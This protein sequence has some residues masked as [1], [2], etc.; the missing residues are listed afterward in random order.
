MGNM[1]ISPG[2]RDVVLAARKGLFIID[3]EN[4]LNVPR[5]LP[6]GGTWDVADVQWN[7]HISRKEY[8]VSTS[9]EKLLIWNL[10]ISGKT[11]IEHILRSHYRAITD[12]NWHL[13]DPD[14]VVST[15]IDSWLWAW[16][17]RT[18]QKPIIGLCAFN[19][20]GT[21]VKWNRQDGNILASS[22]MNEVLVWDRRKGSLPVT[23][24]KAHDAKIY[25]IDWAHDK[26]NE[27]VTCSLDTTI[28]AWDILQSPKSGS[29]HE[30]LYTIHT[31][32]P[33]WRARNLPF[34]KGVLSLPQRGETA[35]EMW[36]PQD[37][38]EPVERFEGHADVVKEFV[39]RKGGQDDS[40][41]QLITWSKDRT[42]RFWPVDRE[43]MEKVG[44]S[45]INKSSS[46]P[47]YFDDRVSFSNPPAGSEPPPALSAPI[48]HRSILAEVRATQ[49]PR[50]SKVNVLRQSQDTIARRSSSAAA[51]K[52]AKTVQQPLKERS[53]T[54]SRGYVG[55]RSAQITTFAWLSSVKVGHK[56][57]TSSGP[58]SGADSG[59]A[60]RLNSRSRPPSVVDPAMSYLDYRAK[61]NSRDR[62]DEDRREVD[63]NQSLQE[64][65]T[66]V[67][68]RL[69][70]SKVKLEKADLV[71][72]RTCTFGLHGPWGDGMSVFIRIS[73][74]FPKDYPQASHPGGTPQ[75][76]LERN[77]LI[78]MK[79][80][81][82]ILRR[83][84]VIREQERPC[85]EACLRF[86]LF[87]DEDTSSRAPSLDSESSSE[88][89]LG[90]TARRPKEGTTSLLR[91]DKNLAEPR[92]SQGVFGPNGELVCFFRAPPRIVK[93]IGRDIS[94]SPSPGAHSETTPRLF[95]SPILLSDA[96]RRL[97]VAANDREVESVD[98]R[99]AENAHS[100]LRIMS[101]LFTFSSQPGQVGQKVR[102]V[103]EHSKPSE[104]AS[105]IYSPLPNRRSTVYIKDTS[106]LCAID[107]AVARDYVF[108]SSDLVAACKTNAGLAKF[109]GRLDH[110]RFFGILQVLAGDTQKSGMGHGDRNSSYAIRNPMTASMMDR[111]YEELSLAKDIQML[112]MFS[113]VVLCLAAETPMLVTPSPMPRTPHQDY[114]TLR[115]NSQ[116]RQSP[117]SN[118]W[119]RTSPSPSTG[120][121]VA[122][123]LSSPSS[124]RGSWSS[125]FNA[126]SMRKLITASKAGSAVPVSRSHYSPQSPLTKDPKRDSPGQQAT[127]RSWT[128]PTK[129]WSD[130]TD[131]SGSRH[132]TLSFSSSGP[133][134]RRPTFSQ[135]VSNS[136]QP[137]KKRVSVEIFRDMK[138]QRCPFRLDPRLRLQL[139]AHVWAYADM[140]LAWGLSQKRAE[141]LDATRADLIAA[142]DLTHSAMANMFNSSPLGI[143]RT[144]VSCSQINEPK[145]EACISCSGRLAVEA[146]SICRLPVR[147]LSHTCLVC[148]HASHVR[149]WRNRQDPSCPTGCG[150]DCP[151]SVAQTPIT[152]SPSSMRYNYISVS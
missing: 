53:E 14:V 132:T 58:P 81:V 134:G 121:L 69:S 139:E 111:L 3:L 45:S 77:P 76:D 10:Y 71:K 66:S 79:T 83:L 27:I 120:N 115:R 141:L 42:L 25:G 92:T 106:I 128:D 96:M 11:S 65:I 89:E 13:H 24:I 112:A 35:L 70:A 142:P 88:D 56:R 73:F 52:I 149:C 129:S 116:A 67:I 93:N 145:A 12:I 22:H 127:S 86:L 46:I 75:V 100:I 136:S 131:L 17:L 18:P 44:T 108:P 95:W 5:F 148:L 19:A 47:G 114:F 48:G 152:Q 6:Q 122:P 28:K 38:S 78:S 51:R 140:L 61:S 138:A 7:P 80:R 99:R 2:S 21:Q 135:I 119:A 150:C 30:P 113:V 118:M 133:R 43:V 147:G 126:T 87:G 16:D 85:L 97:A 41:F 34:G 9:S 64:E 94:A 40:E 74:T 103:S 1:S 32:Y 63:A 105:N 60:S 104:D 124:S 54:M 101:N 36:T 82:H 49:P 37:L 110:E 117:I 98:M 102:R 146:C 109:H 143:A 8:I 125:L 137:E 59:H 62:G 39:W 20:A 23:T 57:D 123:P 68:N 31:A 72:R 151:E 91:S 90:I 50:P 55:G 4:P 144:C 33:I 26:R 29:F 15:G 107:V 84:R 130:T